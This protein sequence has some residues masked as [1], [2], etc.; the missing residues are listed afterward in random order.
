MKYLIVIG[1]FFTLYS[2]VDVVGTEELSEV[3]LMKIE[4]DSLKSMHISSTINNLQEIKSWV[5][6]NDLKIRKISNPVDL[7]LAIDIERFNQLRMSIQPYDSS[8]TGIDSKIDAE[9][10]SLDKLYKDIQKGNGDREHYNDYITYEQ[11]KID[12]IRSILLI[13]DSIRLNIIATFNDLEGKLDSSLN[14]I[15]EE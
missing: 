7:N 4:C 3:E 14:Q 1:S 11:L 5:N 10:K 9:Q 8:R 15:L 2:C 12:S 6:Q 13:R